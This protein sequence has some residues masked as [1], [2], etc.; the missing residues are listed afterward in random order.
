MHLEVKGFSQKQSMRTVSAGGERKIAERSELEPTRKS[1]ETECASVH[2]E[3]EKL[4]TSSKLFETFQNE[5]TG[6][7][8]ARPDLSSVPLK[9]GG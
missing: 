5:S 6:R 8:N 3:P 7:Q 1:S 9:S 2:F 4:E